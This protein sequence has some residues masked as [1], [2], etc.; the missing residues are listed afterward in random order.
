MMVTAARGQA[1]FAEAVHRVLDAE[2][3]NR[4]LRTHPPGPRAIDPAARCA[5]MRA[6][7]SARGGFSGACRPA[8]TAA[9]AATSRG[10]APFTQSSG[11]GRA[12]RLNAEPAAAAV[13]AGR[14]G[15]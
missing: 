5:V 9:S 15:R 11:H 1:D 2:F 6:A 4:C 12:H 7:G 8:A 10:R 3:P 13:R 14:S